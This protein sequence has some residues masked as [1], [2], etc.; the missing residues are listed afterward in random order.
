MCERSQPPETGPRSQRGHA[1]SFQ[2]ERAK[3]GSGGEEGGGGWLLRG[4]G[5][6]VVVERSDNT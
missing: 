1:V 3:R 5:R 2:E 4:M 6:E